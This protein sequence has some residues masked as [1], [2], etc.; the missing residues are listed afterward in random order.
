MDERDED[1]EISRG[2]NLRR[3]RGGDGVDDVESHFVPS[4]L[5]PGSLEHADERGGVRSN[6]SIDSTRAPRV[7]ACILREPF[8]GRRRA[9]PPE[10]IANVGPR[11]RGNLEPEQTGEEGLDERAL[12]RRVE[13]IRGV[14]ETR[15]FRAMA[16]GGESHR[17]HEPI[18]DSSVPGDK[19]AIRLGVLA[20]VVVIR[21]RLRRVPS[22]PREK[23]QTR[24]V[25]FDLLVGRLL[26]AHRRGSRAKRGEYRL[27]DGAADA[28]ESRHHAETHGT[29]RRTTRTRT[30]GRDGG[31]GEGA[32]QEIVLI[33]VAVEVEGPV[34]PHPGFPV[35]LLLGVLFGDEPV[36]EGKV[37]APVHQEVARHLPRGHEQSHAGE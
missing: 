26:G 5:H 19:L 24:R 35:R 31:G 37:G 12:Y 10:G 14:H 2:D 29:P 36:G 27:H 32:F 25:A 4:R 8:R 30:I 9:S 1:R 21:Q 13:H 20:L 6:G 22:E 15:E 17:V 11:L 18:R 28:D 16:R 7:V 33:G 3:H 34:V 23:E